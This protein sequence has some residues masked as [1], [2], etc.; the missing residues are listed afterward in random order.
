M[1][2]RVHEWPVSAARYSMT[3]VFPLEVGPCSVKAVAYKI[4]VH[5]VLRR[6]APHL[7]QNRVAPAS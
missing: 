6:V 1:L 2:M 4:M 7:Q 3:L 5:T